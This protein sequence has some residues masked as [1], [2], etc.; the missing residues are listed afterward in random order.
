MRSSTACEPKRRKLFDGRTVLAYHE[1][2]H[3]V[4]GAAVGDAPIHVS[5]VG[6]EST[7]GHTT[8]RMIARPSSLAQI[9][10]AGFAA[11]HALTGRRA[12]QLDQEVGF[13]ILTLEASDLLEAFANAEQRDGHRAVKELLRTAPLRNANEVRAEVERHYDAAR[14][15]LASIWPAVERVAQA[16]LQRSELGREELF[17]ALGRLDIYGPVLA[18]QIARGLR[19]DTS[20]R[21]MR[22]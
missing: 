19:V 22:F 5:I 15:S 1:A 11:E 16:L 3:A 2:G 17:D 21:S 7:Q 14:A 8:Q 6:D 9:Y 18:V 20:A 10:L 13:S 12:R 4:L